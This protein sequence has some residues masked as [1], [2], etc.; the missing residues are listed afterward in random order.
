MHVGFLQAYFARESIG[1]GEVHTE[2]LGR[3][4]Q[5]RGHEVTVY[6]DEPDGPRRSVPEL[7]V[8][9]YPTPLKLNPVTEL[10]LARR[11]RN[12]LEQCDVVVLTDESGFL[13]VDIG[14]PTVMV[15][16]LVWHGW[17]A[18][19]GLSTLWQKPQALAYAA[20]E[21]RI[22]RRADRVVA[23]SPNMA[24]DIARISGDLE[25]V[26][27]PN[28]VDTERFTPREK[29][30]EFTVHFQGR[31][32]EM[33]N[34]DRLVEAV[35]Q[36]DGGWRL[37][38]GGDGPMR[39]SLE[40]RVEAAGVADRVEF[41]GYLPEDELPERYARSHLYALPSTYEG[42]PLTVLE[43]AASGTGIVASPRAATDFVTEEMGAVV[44]PDPTTLA[45][46]LDELARDPDRVGRMGEAARARAEDYS[47]AAIAERYEATFETLTTASATR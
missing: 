24:E 23:I 31:L 47:W 40:A 45:A 44:D 8:R 15:F 43:A 22:A 20:M 36:S 37:T 5:N 34:P 18:R 2:M 27:I 42:M 46:T 1:G 41:L 16:H 12:D 11:A 17:L 26:D 10:A 4:L 14:P 30:D 7:E 35:V 6:T 28:G 9:T 39:E 25:V 32:V 21:R 33:K 13:G 3:A 29:Y 38:I 19:H